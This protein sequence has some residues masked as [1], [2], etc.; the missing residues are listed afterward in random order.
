[1]YYSVNQKEK[2]P[3]WKRKNEEAMWKRKQFFFNN[4]VHVVKFYE[5]TWWIPLLCHVN[6]N[7][8]ITHVILIKKMVNILKLKT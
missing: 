2:E 4:L 8:I 3:M 5:N 6:T 7:K 1:M